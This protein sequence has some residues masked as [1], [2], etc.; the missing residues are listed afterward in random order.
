MTYMFDCITDMMSFCQMSTYL[1]AFANGNFEYI[2]SEYVSPL[3]GK[4]RP[5]RV[6]GIFLGL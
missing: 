4:K 1:V 2:E 5:L 6:Y 3:S